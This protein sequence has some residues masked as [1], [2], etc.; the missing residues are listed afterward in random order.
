MAA[1]MAASSAA[2]A[3]RDIGVLGQADAHGRPDRLR[4]AVGDQ[5][6]ADRGLDLVAEL[7]DGPVDLGLGQPVA[8]RPDRRAAVVDGAAAVA[9]APAAAPAAASAGPAA[10]AGALALAVPVALEQVLADALEV[11]G[12]VD[13]DPVHHPGD[14]PARLDIGEPPHVL[15]G[16][17]RPEQVVVLAMA[18]RSASRSSSSDSPASGPSSG[19]DDGLPEV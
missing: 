10:P 6:P 9:E 19:S 4:A 12:L 7:R 16:Q 5:R 17:H 1:A 13:R 11:G 8:Q 15:V 2:D 18:S 3:V 14:R